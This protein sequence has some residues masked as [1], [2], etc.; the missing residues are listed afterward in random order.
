MAGDYVAARDYYQ[1]L[2]RVTPA[3]ESV[4]G[5]MD[6]A[7]EWIGMHRR[8]AA[9]LDQL[10]HGLDYYA[11]PRNHV[12]IVAL[13]YYSEHLTGML[14]LAATIEKSYRDYTAAEGDIHKQGVAF[15][16]AL[17]GAEESLAKLREACAETVVKKRELQKA[18][19]ELTQD[20]QDQERALVDF[21]D[22]F[23]DAVQRMIEEKGE[24]EFLKLLTSVIAVSASAVSVVGAVGAVGSL[25]E[26]ATVANYITK[27]AAV[28]K[29]LQDLVGKWN[30][31]KSI[32]T[33][34]TP[35]AGKLVMAQEDFDEAIKPLLDLPEAAEYR[36][37]VHDY[38]DI[39]QAR[40][41]KVLEFNGVYA[42]G[43]QLDGEVLQKQKAIARIKGDWAA[44][45]DPSLSANRTFMQGVY[46]DTKSWLLTDLYF[47]NQAL[48]YWSLEMNPFEVGDDSVA[49]LA[50]FHTRIEQNMLDFM[51][52]NVTPLQPFENLKVTIDSQSRPQQFDAFR[53]TGRITFAA[54][55]NEPDSLGLA[56]VMAT[57]FSVRMDGVKTS[58]N[59][60]YTILRHSGRSQFLD[61]SGKSITFVHEVRMAFYKAQVDDGTYQAG[62]SLGGDDGKYIGVS[63]FTAWNLHLPRNDNPGL[64]LSAV[65]S[66]TLTFKGRCYPLLDDAARKISVE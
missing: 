61:Q 35:D 4:A 39:I 43:A 57:G 11:N 34:E 9:L 54:S 30:G 33:Q 16:D 1:W 47:E 42:V 12:P 60:L 45:Q 63:P 41:D 48:N 6:D 27:I 38:L 65:D 29:G 66:I 56:V 53:K 2:R 55:P 17:N 18:I 36:N 14:A 15:E 37:Q 25:E 3:S 51:K 21:R 49:E 7:D 10:G 19:N 44:K 58:N 40:N 13:E 23:N 31:I 26:G 32:V 59:S 64:D 20:Q 24:V 50:S 28:S 8:A 22:A 5:E 52:G 62:G 46:Q